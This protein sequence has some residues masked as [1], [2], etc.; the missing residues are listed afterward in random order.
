MARTVVRDISKEAVLLVVAHPDAVLEQQGVS[1]Y[2]KLVVENSK[3][4]LYRVFINF[5]KSPALVITVYK[6]SKLEKYGY[7]I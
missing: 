2:S 4:Y 7:K 1:I 5:K 6:T 3:T